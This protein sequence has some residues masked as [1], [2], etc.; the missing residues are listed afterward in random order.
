ML[1]FSRRKFLKL[2]GLSVMPLLPVSIPFIAGANDL[3]QKNNPVDAARVSFLNDG[4]MYRPAEYIA[5]LDEI[6]K[7][8]AIQRDSYAEG[9]AVE[10]SLTKILV[11]TGK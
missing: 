7:A 6:N 1:D 8:N 10:Q 9:G 3:K 11:M 4:P 5:K 2:S